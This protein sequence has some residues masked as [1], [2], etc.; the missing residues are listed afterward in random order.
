M[1]IRMTAGIGVAFLVATI[2]ALFLFTPEPGIFGVA[3]AWLFK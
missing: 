1:V 2:A 3:Q